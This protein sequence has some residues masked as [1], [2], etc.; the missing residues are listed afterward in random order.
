MYESE[1]VYLRHDEEKSLV[2]RVHSMPEP[3]FL[4]HFI[5]PRLT[6]VHLHTTH[7]GTCSLRTPTEL[8]RDRES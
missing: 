4:P 7:C 2:D 1:F 3:E 5:L 6:T 8:R